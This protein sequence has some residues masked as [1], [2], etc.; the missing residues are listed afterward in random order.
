MSLNKTW[1]KICQ[2]LNKH[3]FM[4]EEEK[5]TPEQGAEDIQNAENNESVDAQETTAK[6]L[7]EELKATLQEEKDKFMR[8]YAEFENYKKR[9]RKEKEDFVLLA[10]EKLLL[11][12]LPVLD[13]FERAMKEI[14]KSEDTQLV[15]GVQLIQNKLR[16][17]LSKKHLKA[18]DVKAGDEFDADKH[19]AITQIPAPDDSLKGKLV[20]VVSTGYTLGDKVIRYPKVVVGK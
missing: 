12:L 5:L 6:D 8:L 15:E 20:D 4:N 1:Q 3:K 14:E 17:V 2:K 7:Q 16:E 10:N 18:M 19:E 11:D 13:D 9:S